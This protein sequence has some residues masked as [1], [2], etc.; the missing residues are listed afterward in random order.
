MSQAHSWTNHNYSTSYSTVLFAY[1]Q[2]RTYSI[3]PD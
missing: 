2:C 3:A 1:E